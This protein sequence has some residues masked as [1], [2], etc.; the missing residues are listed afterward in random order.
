MKESEKLNIHKLKKKIFQDFFPCQ[1]KPKVSAQWERPNGAKRR[2]ALQKESRGSWE[3]TCAP[4]RNE[5]LAHFLSA[6]PRLLPRGLPNNVPVAARRHFGAANTAKEEH[7]FLD[8]EQN[9]Q[10]A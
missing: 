10:I 2:G 9:D 6:R 1:G 7:W 8:E 3:A 5:T 4:P